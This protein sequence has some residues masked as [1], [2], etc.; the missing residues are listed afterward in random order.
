MNT[1]QGWE[2]SLSQASGQLSLPLAPLATD[3]QAAQ[4][5]TQCNYCMQPG[6]EK[7]SNLVE[8]EEEIRVMK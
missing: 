7:K 2:C 4:L 6:C 3:R 8:R 5:K 1:V